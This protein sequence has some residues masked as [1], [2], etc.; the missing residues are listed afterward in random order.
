M[1]TC[2]IL[3]FRD[4]V[5]TQPKFFFHRHM[6]RQSKHWKG[7]KDIKTEYY[8]IDDFLGLSIN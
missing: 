7:E 1:L 6:D 3:H 2:D 4:I 5:K 8:E